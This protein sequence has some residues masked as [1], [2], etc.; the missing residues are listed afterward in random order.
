[1]KTY[2]SNK[3]D[4]QNLS[5]FEKRIKNIVLPQLNL[6]VGGYGGGSGSK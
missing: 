3:I 4:A 1:M 6:A 5:I 2:K